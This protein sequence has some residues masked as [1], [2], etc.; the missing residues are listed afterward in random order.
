[1]E[2]GGGCVI[3]LAHGRLGTV[4]QRQRFIMKAHGLGVSLRPTFPHLQEVRARS[5]WRRLGPF[6][7]TLF[8][9]IVCFVELI[10]T[11]TGPSLREFKQ[12]VQGSKEEQE[13]QRLE[14]I[15]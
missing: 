9:G 7:Q 10:G 11:L 2:S 3:K 8:P 6:K 5:H 12:S 15:Q 14:L 13:N 1:M 4:P